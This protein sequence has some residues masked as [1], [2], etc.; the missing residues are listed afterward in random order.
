MKSNFMSKSD[1]FEEN[2]KNKLYF[3][4]SKKKKKKLIRKKFIIYN[5]IKNEFFL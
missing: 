5:R 4:F 1:K 3:I 2:L